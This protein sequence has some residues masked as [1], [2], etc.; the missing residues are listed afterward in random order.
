VPGDPMR[1]AL[2]VLSSLQG[3]VSLSTDGKFK[4]VSLSHLTGDIVERLILGLRPR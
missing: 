4:G 3:L 2:V 1:L